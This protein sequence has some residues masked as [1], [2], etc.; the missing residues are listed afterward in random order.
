MANQPNAVTVLFGRHRTRIVFIG[1]ALLLGAIVVLQRFAARPDA[2]AVEAKPAGIPVESAL[3]TRADVPVE[4]EGLGT[5]QGFN[6]VK[7][8]PRVDGQLERIGFVEGQVVKKG[9]FLAQIDV[10]PF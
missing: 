2:A 10:C 3:A 7:I 9:A 1:I 5:V 6:T 4:L 8:T